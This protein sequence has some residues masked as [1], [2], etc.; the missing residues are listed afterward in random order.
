MGATTSTTAITNIYNLIIL[1]ESGSMSSIYEQALGGANETIQTIRAAQSSANDQKQFLTFVTFDSGT[2]ESVRT[3]IDT[4]PIEQVK[5]LTRDDYRPNGCTP[6]YDAMGKSLTALE[7]KVTDDDQVLVTIITDGM[8]NSSCEYTGAAICD[9]VK[10]LRAKGWTF[11]YIGANQDAVEVA[12]RMNIDNAMNFQAT[13]EDTRRMWDD[14]KGSTSAYYEKVRR[15]KMRGERIFEDKEFFG[16]RGPVTRMT[17]DRITT[18]G[19]GEIFVFG[20]V[21]KD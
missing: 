2:G 5:D 13:H 17:P 8:E 6:L 12:K 1:D 11:V 18:L 3:V 20:S 14:Y 21:C 19:S 9:I 16:S 15:S 4:M 7:K 10:R